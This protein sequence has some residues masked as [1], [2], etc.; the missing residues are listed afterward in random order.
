VNL[1]IA[2][3]SFLYKLL[4]VGKTAIADGIAQCMVDGNVPESLIN[5]RLIGL[6][7]GALVAGAS[8]QGEFEECLKADGEII[9]F[10]DDM[11]TVVGAGV[12]QGSMDASNLLK[13][14]FP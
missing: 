13:P 2:N 1:F 8:M 9:L 11:H 7:L 12:S 3:I 4:N 6:D 5:C 14:A 10:I